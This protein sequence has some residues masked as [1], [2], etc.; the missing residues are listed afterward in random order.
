M[1]A[2]RRLSPP[3]LPSAAGPALLL[4][5]ASVGEGGVDRRTRMLLRPSALCSRLLSA[6]KDEPN[7]SLSLVACIGSVVCRT[8]P[9]SFSLPSSP[10]DTHFTNL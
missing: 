6:K 4:L 2:Q 9:L 10:S 5:L 8:C 7:L 3:S 1:V